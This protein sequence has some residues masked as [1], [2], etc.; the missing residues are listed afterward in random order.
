MYSFCS[1]L[2][3][4]LGDE[5]FQVSI[6]KHIFPYL[7]IP[8]VFVGAWCSYL[9]YFFVSA[10]T[11]KDHWKYQ[12]QNCQVLIANDLRVTAIKSE[13]IQ[14]GIIDVTKAE[15]IMSE[16]DPT[17]QFVLYLCYN[18]NCRSDLFTVIQVV[19]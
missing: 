10:V 14:A 18:R 11:P 6:N 9:I 1:W 13:L 4:R 2:L 3:C 17:S 16:P 8:K 15:E 7:E 5:V 12:L 19:Q